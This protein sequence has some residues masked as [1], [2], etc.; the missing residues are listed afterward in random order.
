MNIFN[1]L[2]ESFRYPTPGLA[3]E[4]RLG[5]GQL[6]AGPVKKSLEAFLKP[7]QKLPPGEWEELYTRT[8]DLNPLATPYVGF[9]IYGESY[10][11]GNFMA[12]LN[13]EMRQHQ[14]DLGGEL[15][16][17]LLPVLRYLGSVSEPIP[18]L[19][20]ALPSAVRRMGA[21]LR[22][23]EPGN[24]YV[25]LLDAVEQACQALKKPDPAKRPVMS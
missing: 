1:L 3:E 7:L 16:D 22:K 13:R 10:Q 19:V 6:P 14:I 18:E 24:P 25:H 11:R 17:H 2:A 12:S 23:A 15:P 20:E 8:L 5:L 9:Q 4:L 21:V